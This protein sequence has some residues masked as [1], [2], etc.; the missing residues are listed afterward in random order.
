MKR[1]VNAFF[2]MVMLLSFAACDDANNTTEYYFDGLYTVRGEMLWPEQQ[3]TFYVAPNVK[4]MGLKTGDRALLRVRCFVDNVFGPLAAQWSVDKVFGH[5]PT[6]SIENIPAADSVLY[7]SSFVGITPCFNYGT[8]WIWNGVQN[9]NVVYYTNGTEP[10]FRMTAPAFVDDTLRLTLLS[11][12]EDGEE[13]TSNLLSF[14]L[15]SALPLLK[16]HEQGLLA[17]KDTLRTKITMRYYDA[18]AD[19]VYMAK[20]FAGLCANPFRK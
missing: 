18:V 11:K 13:L 16:N 12:F 20:F 4:S 7:N 15:A 17:G 8:S 1:F 5:I 9:V 19:T 6:R 2:A 10:D 3:D 14:D